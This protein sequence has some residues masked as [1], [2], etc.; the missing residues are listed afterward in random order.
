MVYGVWRLVS[1]ECVCV[2]VRSVMHGVCVCGWGFMFCKC[3]NAWGGRMRVL[4]V[5]VHV[6]VFVDVCMAHQRV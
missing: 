6:S 5:R 2:R 3:V 1:G 4:S